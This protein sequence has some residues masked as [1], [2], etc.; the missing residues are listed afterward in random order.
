MM[1][2]VPD[3]NVVVSA[4]LTPSGPPFEI[5][6]LASK[7]LIQLCVSD[8]VFD[9]Y[10]EVLGRPQFA[11]LRELSNLQLEEILKICKF[12]TPSKRVKVSP[13]P[14]DDIFLECAEAAKAQYLITGNVRDFPDRWKYTSVVT[15]RQFLNLFG[16]PPIK[17]RR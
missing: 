9:E 5:I 13:D 8:A 15:P 6:N 2:V 4:V 12:V 7:G 11:K 1:R 3:T 17:I 10:R 16:T 14:D